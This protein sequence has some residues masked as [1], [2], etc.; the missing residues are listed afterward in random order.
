MIKHVL[1]CQIRFVTKAKR[2]YI[3]QTAMAA[4]SFPA[5]LGATPLILAS[6]P[7]CFLSSLTFF[8]RRFSISRVRFCSLAALTTDA[9]PPCW[10]VLEVPTSRDVFGSQPRLAGKPARCQDRYHLVTPPT[11]AWLNLGEVPTFSHHSGGRVSG[12]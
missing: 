3:N 7:L 8:R 1:Q 10:L 11:S 12:R 5:W 6:I 9:N 2:A 4:C